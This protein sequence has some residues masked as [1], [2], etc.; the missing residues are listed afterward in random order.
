VLVGCVEGNA[1]E[2]QV[3]CYNTKRK[4]KPENTTFLR[5][6]VYQGDVYVQECTYANPKDPV[7]HTTAEHGKRMA[8][9]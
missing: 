4:G 5:H 1:A 3:R 6:E 2:G 7:V 8:K 9:V